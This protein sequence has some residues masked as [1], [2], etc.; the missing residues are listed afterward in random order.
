MPHSRRQK[1]ENIHDLRPGKIEANQIM[2]QL[3][4][5][6]RQQII[7]V[8][9]SIIAT[10]LQE[11]TDVKAVQLSL[12]NRAAINRTL[13]RQKQTTEN[14]DFCLFDSGVMINTE[15]I[16]IFGVRDNVQNG[17]IKIYLMTIT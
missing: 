3:K 16:L 13:N 6:A 8:N 7:P 15:R 12:P 4:K 1:N 17:L 2:H 9:S 11:T 10:C 5:E 14:S